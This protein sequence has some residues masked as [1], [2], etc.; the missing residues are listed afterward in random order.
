MES[1][2]GEVR[3]RSASIWSSLRS[4]NRVFGSMPSLSQTARRVL[5]S[6]DDFPPL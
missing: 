5:R 2:S 3:L 6:G 4:Q 1:S